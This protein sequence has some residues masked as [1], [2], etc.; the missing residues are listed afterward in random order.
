MPFTQERPDKRTLRWVRKRFRIATAVLAVSLFLFWA[1]WTASESHALAAASSRTDGPTTITTRSCEKCHAHARQGQQ[2]SE[3]VSL[4]EFGRWLDANRP[5]PHSLPDRPPA[6][7]KNPFYRDPILADTMARRLG[8][9]HS[10]QSG[11]CLACHWSPDPTERNDVAFEDAISYGMGCL[12]C[13][14]APENWIQPHEFWRVRK[15]SDDAKKQTGYVCLNRWDER[16]EACA[17]CHVGAPA[18]KGLSPRDLTH[19]MYAAGHPWKPYEFRRY[20]QAMNPHWNIEFDRKQDP[21][22]D[23]RAWLSG[24]IVGARTLV[25]QTRFRA[26]QAKAR[27]AQRAW[28]ELTEFDCFACHRDLGR[29]PDVPEF[30]QNVDPAALGRATWHGDS[31]FPLM[32]KIA[33]SGF[34]KDDALSAQWEELAQSTAELGAAPD[35]IIAAA[36]KL[37]A[38]LTELYQRIEKRDDLGQQLVEAVRGWLQEKLAESP[39]RIAP[40]E[41]LHYAYAVDAVTNTSVDDLF[42]GDKVFTEPGFQSPKSFS[43]AEPSLKETLQALLA[44]LPDR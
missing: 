23:A 17:G 13:H 12:S 21:D 27:V 39:L 20:Q 38:S 2:A 42:P 30:V 36:T 26:E 15:T 29:T 18:E 3:P 28:P 31:T 14:R 6:K 8:L 34:L 25:R 33:K 24:Q 11:E 41:L 4:D 19:D 10:S 9:E 7:N 16:V 5:D 37:D 43:P 22:F 35:P 44:R 40:E 32:R 1:W